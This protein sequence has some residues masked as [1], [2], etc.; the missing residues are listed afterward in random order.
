MKKLGLVIDPGHYP[1]YNPGIIPTIYEGDV[2]FSLAEAEK[3]YCDEN[4]SNNVDCI[5]T[6]T[7]TENPSLEAG[8]GHKAVKLK[9]SGNYEKIMFMSDHTN[10]PGGNPPNP[11]ITGICI[12]TSQFRKNTDSFLRK[13]GDEVARI[14]NSHFL[15]MDAKPFKDSDTSDWWGVVRGAM[16]HARNQ[17]EADKRGVDYAFILEHG[18]HTNPVECAYFGEEAN[19]FK[20][21]KGKIDF[22]MKSLGIPKNTEKTSMTGFWYCD[23]TINIK[24]PV[25]LYSNSRL[26][27]TVK[28]TAIAGTKHRAVQGVQMSDKTDWYRLE[29]GLYI[30]NTSNISYT[31]NKMKRF[32]VSVNSPDNAL[33]MRNFPNSSI[34]SVKRTFQN[35][36]LL[37]V[38][39][40]AY[41]SGDHWYLVNQG[42]AKEK[43]S[44]FVA[45]R[46]VK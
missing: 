28:G 13:L 3:K 33:N 38:I 15:Y 34:G 17:T 11:N 6:R 30:Q 10:A 7:R 35:G 12:F 14:M 22:I 37:E 21:A 39:G 45:A 16:D 26:N 5:L 27:S 40:E 32:V 1:K 18:F 41:N 46:Y 23:G 43:F 8:R 19:I 24:V 42:N 2:M 44:G 36:N 20:M 29:T 4:Y 25:S 31:D 9:Q